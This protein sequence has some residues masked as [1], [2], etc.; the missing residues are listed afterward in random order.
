M[1]QKTKGSQRKSLRKILD[2]VHS[3]LIRHIYGSVCVVCGSTENIECGHIFT[4]GGDATR[5]DTAEGGNCYPQ[6]HSCNAKHEQDAKPYE[7]WYIEKYG[8]TS[9]DNLR[10]RHSR[11]LKL[12]DSDLKAMITNFQN[13][14]DAK[15]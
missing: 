7:S 5:W 11:I 1:S 2:S 3:K 8:Q 6:C 9:F 10:R 14:I 12:A 15:A 4:R 13:K